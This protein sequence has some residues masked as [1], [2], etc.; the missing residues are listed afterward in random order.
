MT[1]YDS[2]AKAVQEVPREA[3]DAELVNA[4]REL[5]E[6]TLVLAGATETYLRARAEHSAAAEGFASAFARV[7]QLR[8]EAKA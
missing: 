5:G 7:E 6:R 2:I 3:I 4:E 8:A 1:G